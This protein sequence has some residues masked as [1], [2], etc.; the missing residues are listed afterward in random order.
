MQISEALKP[1]AQAT[2]NLR[3][4]LTATFGKFVGGQNKEVGVSVE[5][6]KLDNKWEYTLQETYHEGGVAY[7]LTQ[8]QINAQTKMF[9]T[10]FEKFRNIGSF[11]DDGPDLL[12]FSLGG[13]SYLLKEYGPDALM[14]LNVLED[15]HKQEARHMGL[16]DFIASVKSEYV[17]TF[18][19]SELEVFGEIIKNRMVA[20]TL[21]FP[22]AENSNQSGMSVREENQFKDRI[23]VAHQLPRRKYIEEIAD[24]IKHSNYMPVEWALPLLTDVDAQISK[25]KRIAWRSR[26]KGAADW[27]LPEQYRHKDSSRN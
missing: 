8:M 22:R 14:S 27:T 17:W 16:P 6:P 2:S 10:A 1:V 9:M 4:S 24:D 18:S 21:S 7:E 19:E 23:S 15:H 5:K 12:A 20:G 3:K 25:W 26:G 11:N 13:F